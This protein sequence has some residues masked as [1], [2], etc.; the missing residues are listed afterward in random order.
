M[1]LVFVCQA[2]GCHYLVPATLDY[3]DG[4][5]ASAVW[6][7]VCQHA[8]ADRGIAEP[9]ELAAVAVL[10]AVRALKAALAGRD[11]RTVQDG[12]QARADRRPTRPAVSARGRTHPA[13][14][15]T[16]LA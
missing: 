16:R 11:A 7:S 15:R 12:R 3:P 14:A 13:G 4:G 5:R 9:A 2:C 1:T 6:C 8:A 10:L